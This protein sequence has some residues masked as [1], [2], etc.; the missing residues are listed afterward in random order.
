[1]KNI[2]LD[3]AS[4]QNNYLQKKGKIFSG[5]VIRKCYIT[6]T[7]FGQLK[8]QDN[9]ES[10]KTFYFSNFYVQLRNKEIVAELAK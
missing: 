6:S 10:N 8:N 2:I 9:A 3:L 4:L 1:M 5:S 7:S